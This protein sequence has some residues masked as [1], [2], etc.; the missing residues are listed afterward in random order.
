V[1]DGGPPVDVRAVFHEATGDIDVCYVNT[2]ATPSIDQG[3]GATVGLQGNASVQL[4]YSC[5][6][7]AV[8]S[9]TLLH[10]AHP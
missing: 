7:P 1:N 5:D 10:Y 9:G 3:Q 2:A 6:A 4:P 8:P